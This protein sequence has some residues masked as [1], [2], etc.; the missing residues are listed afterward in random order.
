MDIRHDDVPAS[1]AG[2]VVAVHRS[3]D[4]TFSKGAAD[5]VEVA[6]GLGVV[7]DA[8]AGATVKHRS[9]V[10]RDPDQPNLRQVHLV[11]AELLA[12]MRERGFDVGP[13][14]IGENVTTS[15]IDLV[16][17]PTGTTLRIG[18]VILALTGLRN[19]CGQI[20]GFRRG[21]RHAMIGTA[22]DGGRLLRT[23]V[24]AVVVHGGT[25]SVGD[26]ILGAEPAGPSIP[27]QRI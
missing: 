6:A 4:H 23:G 20:D 22:P 1:I 25:I 10:A 14:D 11:T 17:L 7:G 27:M 18:D 3:G 12:E 5:R 24:M 15:G 8:H 2:T 16:A 21:M 13:G 9:R 26:P 19:P